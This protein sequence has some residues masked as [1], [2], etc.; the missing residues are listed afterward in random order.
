[1]RVALNAEALGSVQAQA[2]QQHS[3]DH[4]ADS[5][6][7]GD[8]PLWSHHSAATGCGRCM[9]AAEGCQARIAD[10]RAHAQSARTAWRDHEGE[11]WT[12]SHNYQSN[13]AMLYVRMMPN[14]V[15]VPA[16]GGGAREADE[17]GTASPVASRRVAP[18]AYILYKSVSATA[19]AVYCTHT[20]YVDSIS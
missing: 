5:H 13:A 6:Q 17:R 1:M 20:T 15:P 4:G 9:G 2:W 18:G 12:T 3:N 11:M 19:V 10:S 16:C 7:P 14:L 8:V